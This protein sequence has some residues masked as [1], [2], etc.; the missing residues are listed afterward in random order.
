M[1]NLT[2]LAAGKRRRSIRREEEALQKSMVEW[3]RWAVPAPPDGPAFFHIPNG[4]WRTKTEAAILKA[5]GVK[6]GAPDLGMI[7]RGRFL[8]PEVKV[9]GEG[10]EPHQTALH[11]EWRLAGAVMT[12][13]HSIEEL[14]NFLIVCGVPVRATA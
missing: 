9:P 7:W 6:R 10:L 5:M 12:T 2:Q 8:G 11:H 13:V 3:L 1:T 14:R 4:G